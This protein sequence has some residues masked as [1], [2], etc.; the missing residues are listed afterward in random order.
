MTSLHMICGLAPPPPN[1]KS[2]LR[3]CV[4]GMIYHYNHNCNNVSQQAAANEV[5]LLRSSI[6][7]L[8]VLILSKNNFMIVPFFDSGISEY[9]KIVV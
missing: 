7:V 2:W 8:V 1:Q 5:T 9:R 6:S 3:L 4:R